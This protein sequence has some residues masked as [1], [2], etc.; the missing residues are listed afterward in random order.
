MSFICLI[1]AFPTHLML[2]AVGVVTPAERAVSIA[3]KLAQGVLLWGGSLS[4]GRWPDWYAANRTRLQA[5]LFILVQLGN[6][7]VHTIE[8]QSSLRPRPAELHFYELQIVSK[9]ALS[10]IVHISLLR[11]NWDTIWVDA[12]LYAATAVATAAAC[13]AAAPDE[14]TMEAGKLAV[15]LFQL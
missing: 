9:G 11:V 12:G 1:L 2:D 6:I 15:L 10:L 5:V 3:I 13:C 4:A 7:V 14:C 8:F